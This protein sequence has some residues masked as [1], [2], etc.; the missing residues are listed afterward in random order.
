MEN[1]LE[2][3]KKAQ[4][5]DTAALASLK[6]EVFLSGRSI[7]SIVNERRMIDSVKLAEL[8]LYE[9]QDSFAKW[10]ADN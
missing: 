7:E 10:V 4:L 2:E 1:F 9:T 8:K 3:I 5:L 6:R